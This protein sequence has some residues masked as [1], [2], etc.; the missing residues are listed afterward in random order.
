MASLSN[1]ESNAANT[2]RHLSRTRSC[3]R[4]YPPL[5]VTSRHRQD[6]ALGMVR[7]CERGE[8]HL[9]NVVF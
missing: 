2:A 5:S 4:L 8:F 9:D 7:I 1:V 6:F 3:G